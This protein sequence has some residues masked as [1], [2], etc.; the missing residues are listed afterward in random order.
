M[1]FP[2]GTDIALTKIPSNCIEIQF[3]GFVVFAGKPILINYCEVSYI[4]NSLIGQV[5]LQSHFT[6]FTCVEKLQ[7]TVHESDLHKL[8]RKKTEPYEVSFKHQLLCFVYLF[9][10]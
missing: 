5:N 10:V 6:V 4:I 9:I 3:Q 2:K 1:N 7:Y 8:T